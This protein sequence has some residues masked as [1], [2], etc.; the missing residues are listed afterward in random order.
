MRIVGAMLG[1]AMFSGMDCAVVVTKT[2]TFKEMGSYAPER[3]FDPTDFP[4]FYANAVYQTTDQFPGFVND[5]KMLRAS[6]YFK[7]EKG[8]R[9]YAHFRHHNG[10][11]AGTNT[12]GCDVVLFYY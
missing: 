8:D 7:F 6:D 10:S 2:G 5:W 1:F 3:V 12:S 9:F 11:T 4:M